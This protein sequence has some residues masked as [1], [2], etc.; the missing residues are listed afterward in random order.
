[1]EGCLD[2]QI[3]DETGANFSRDFDFHE[4]KIFYMITCVLILSLLN[5]ESAVIMRAKHR[6]LST[7]VVM[8][9]SVLKENQSVLKV[10]VIWFM[11]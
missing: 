9:S 4:E 1:M 7:N 11:T 6:Q 10:S 3:D 5:S 2:E 8:G